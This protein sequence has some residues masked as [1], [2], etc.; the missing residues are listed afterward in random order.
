MLVIATS[1]HVDHGKSSL[2]QALTG[3]NPDRLKDEQI[4]EMTIDLGFAFF[5]TPG[6]Q[7]IGIVDVPG[8]I[9]FIENMLA[10]MGGI[11]AVL[12]I[13]AADEGIMLQTRE[14]VAILDLLEINQGV[15]AL[16]KIDLVN[17]PDWIGLVKDDIQDLLKDTSLE[18]F[19]IVEVS[20]RT[21]SGIAELILLIEKFRKNP[22]T[23]ALSAQPRL[24]VDRVF[25]IQGFGTIVTGTLVDGSFSNG[26]EVEVFPAGFR[27]KIRGIQSH[28][29]KIDTALPG[30]RA[31]INLTNIDKELIKRGDVLGRPGSLVSIELIDVDVRLLNNEKIFLR[32]NDPVSFYSGTSKC[33]GR[34]RL[35][36]KNILNA[37]EQGFLQIALDRPVCVK[38]E[39]RFIIR[40]SSPSITL[41]GG[42]IINNR[43]EKK[44]K[45]MDYTVLENL[46]IRQT[47]SVLD[48]LI[49]ETRTPKSIAALTK[50]LDRGE[51]EIQSSLQDLI[52]AGKVLPIDLGNNSIRSYVSNEGFQEALVKVEDEI[53]KMH[54]D[55]QTRKGFS[56]LEISKR[57]EIDEPF[58]S[59]ILEK[60]VF[61]GKIISDGHFY[62][63]FGKTVTYSPAQE[64]S[65]RN[66]N[67]MIDL[68]PY[69]PPTLSETT[70][71]L[72]NAFV[73]DLIM[74]GQFIQVSAD[75]IF[76]DK[77]YQT[78]VS[79]VD[80][81]LDKNQ[82]ILVSDL[83]DKFQ[84]SRKYIIPF[85]EHMD[86]IKKTRR[87]GDERIKY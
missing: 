8:H 43:P 32:H 34:I 6:G 3:K 86:R 29:Q 50:I 16:T 18:G 22:I 35:L 82:K 71:I 81:L 33:S 42:K 40:K 70:E 65:L 84:T 61:L 67:A 27:S 28:N 75:I 59:R 46:K 83:R 87:V 13:I 57:T 38:N 31:S 45:L 26:D 15:V 56:L 4:R 23:S 78:L 30:S 72:G 58:L 5:T 77:E 53:D 44:Y 74:N 68:A 85:L 73:K 24:P 54:Q 69:S 64:K 1:G 76:R 52:K 2:V 12:L 79:F 17:D 66:I 11:D 60:L 39:D 55:F 20:A 47:G 36:G 80:Q 51:L 7:E 37:N 25:S 49:R 10:G 19:P 14:H 48:L 62:K 41:G 63:L 21:G 9:D